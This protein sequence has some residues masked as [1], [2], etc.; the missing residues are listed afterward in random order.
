MIL[1]IRIQILCL[2][3]LD[4]IPSVV[5]PYLSIYIKLKNYIY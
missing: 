2:I 1:L 5:F 3:K 4:Y